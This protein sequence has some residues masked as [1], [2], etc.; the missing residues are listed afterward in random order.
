MQ[1][2]LLLVKPMQTVMVCFDG[3]ARPTNPGNGYGSYEVVADG[4]N[5]KVLKI[6]FGSPL[7]N[8]QAEYMATISALK[9]LR[10]HADASTIRLNM[11]S[12][13]KLLVMQTQ[14]SWKIRCLHIRE[15][16]DEARSLLSRYSKWRISWHSRERNVERFGH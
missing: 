3:G 12:D 10:H 7:S 13:S 9:W 11:F 14:G 5:H 6:E 1:T 16:V 15:L 4:L 2:E 8:N